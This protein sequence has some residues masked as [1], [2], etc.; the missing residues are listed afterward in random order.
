MG[1]I[2]EVVAREDSACQI[3]H[4][5]DNDNIYKSK[6]CRERERESGYQWLLSWFHIKVFFFTIF[7]LSNTTFFIWIC[8]IRIDWSVNCTRFTH[9]VHHEISTADPTCFI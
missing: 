5:P 1:S 6:Y 4:L 7:N 2:N 9:I 3:Q 8:R